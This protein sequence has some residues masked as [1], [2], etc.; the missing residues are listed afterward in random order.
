MGTDVFSKYLFQICFGSHIFNKE[1]FPDINSTT[2]F[3]RS[4]GFSG[5]TLWINPFV[6]NDCQN[7]STEGL[8]KGKMDSNNISN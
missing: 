1:K 8:D 2:S 5:I 4:L 3:I 6:N 7:Y